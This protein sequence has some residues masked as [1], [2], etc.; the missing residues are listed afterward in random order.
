M[1]N[2]SR[3]E[4]LKA[5]KGNGM[6]EFFLEYNPPFTFCKGIEIHVQP[7]NI[8]AYTKPTNDIERSFNHTIETIVEEIRCARYIQVVN[9]DFSFMKSNNDIDVLPYLEANKEYRNKQCQAA[10]RSFRLFCQGKCKFKDITVSYLSAYRSF[11]LNSVKRGRRRRYSTNTASTYLKHIKRLFRLAFADR[12]IDFDPSEAIP[13]ITW[14]HTIK[15]ERLTDEE[16][17]AIRNMDYKDQTV[18]RAVMFSIY[19]GLRRS[20]VLN[21]RWNELELYKG[22]YFICITIQK[23][24]NYVRIPITDEAV[25][26]LGTPL[27]SGKIFP[28]LSTSILN[29]KVPELVAAAGITKHITFHCFRHTFA[30]RLLDNNV[31]IPSIASFLGHKYIGSALAYVH[32]TREHLEEVIKKFER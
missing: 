22:R 26:A 29:K 18:K 31:D 11:L 13:G 23:T 12:L 30:M 32:C 17:I 7:L 14:D 25:E 4:I 19:T 8:E 28:L 20:D 15:K 24:G 6:T 16:I 5:D 9:S 3:V 1:E 27:S 21:I 10:V 2:K